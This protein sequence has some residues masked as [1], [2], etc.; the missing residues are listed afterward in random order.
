MRTDLYHLV[1]LSTTTNAFSEDDLTDILAASRRNNPERDITGMLLYSEGGFIQVLEG[2]KEHV[3]DLYERIEQDPRHSSTVMLAEG[4]IEERSFSEWEM[5]FQKVDARAA[6]MSGF[7]SFLDDPSPAKA[8]RME[9]ARPMKLLL[10]F[11]DKHA[12]AAMP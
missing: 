6:H 8:D 10:S 11:K 3:L 9:L 4:S 5:G 2:P 7:S 12:G 1:Y